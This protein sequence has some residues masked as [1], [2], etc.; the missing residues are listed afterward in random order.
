MTR[1]LTETIRAQKVREHVALLART[2]KGVS[3]QDWDRVS[4]DV[5][6]LCDRVEA[7]EAENKRLKRALEP[8]FFWDFDNNEQAHYSVEDIV[9]QYHDEGEEGI[10]EVQQAIQCANAAYIY[11]WTVD[12]ESDDRE[13]VVEKL[14]D[15]DYKHYKACMAFAYA[16]REMWREM[17]DKR[18]AD[19]FAQNPGPIPEYYHGRPWATLDYPHRKYHRTLAHAELCAALQDQ[20]DGQ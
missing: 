16:A 14:S 4:N 1:T 5:L 20:N 10:V 6:A 3:M 13:V 15:D 11:R 9:N 18:A 12:P 8:D 2:I 7:L 19:L 17:V